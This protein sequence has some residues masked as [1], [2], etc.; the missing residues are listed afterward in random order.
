MARLAEL[1]GD[2]PA[3]AVAT[4][5]DSCNLL[6]GCVRVHTNVF[7]STASP[8]LDCADYTFMPIPRAAEINAVAVACSRT[9]CKSRLLVILGSSF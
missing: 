7:C 4:R 8:H 6:D 1:L 2:P 9:D 5:A 3:T